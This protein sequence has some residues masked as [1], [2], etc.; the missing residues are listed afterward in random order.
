MLADAVEAAQLMHLH[1][2]TQDDSVIYLDTVLKAVQ[3]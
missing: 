1:D 2:G 3:L